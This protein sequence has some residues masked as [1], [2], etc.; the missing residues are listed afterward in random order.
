MKIGDAMCFQTG[1]N[2][3]QIEIGDEA[4]FS[5]TITET[6]IYLFAGITG[7]LNP[8]HV[9]EEYAKQT[10][11]KSR[12]AHGGLVECLIAAVLGTK[13]PGLGTVAVEITCRWI[14]PTF[15]GDT[16]LAKAK[17]VE[18]IE[19]KRWIRMSLTWVN[20]RNETVAKGEVVVIPPENRFTKS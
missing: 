4:S 20:H 10:A 14:A 6:D 17:V 2:Y 11:F 19:S 12:V 8:L 16:I 15:P 5:K 18:K 1:K 3:D 9:D 7:D 13:L